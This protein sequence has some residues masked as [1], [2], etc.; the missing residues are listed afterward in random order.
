MPTVAGLQVPLEQYLETLGVGR[1]D[2]RFRD[3]TDVE[4]RLG[5]LAV[6]QPFLRGENLENR[7]LFLRTSQR[8][9]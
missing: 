5:F 4:G 6:E 7:A 1:N 2:A 9:A 3:I 8:P